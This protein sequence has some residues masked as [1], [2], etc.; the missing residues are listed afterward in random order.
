MVEWI[1]GL[2][3]WKVFLHTVLELPW[4]PSGKDCPMQEGQK[5]IRR[6]SVRANQVALQHLPC[7]SVQLIFLRHIFPVL[8]SSGA[9]LVPGAARCLPH[10]CHRTEPHS[11]HFVPC[12]PLC[13]SVSPVGGL[14]PSGSRT[15]VRR[16]RVSHK[17]WHVDCWRANTLLG[18]RQVWLGGG[19]SHHLWDP[20]RGLP[21]LLHT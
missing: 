20:S 17:A 21:L 12:I 6:A 2:S 15:P 7:L 14:Q 11:T 4:K 13:G 16:A 18:N 10:H 9:L 19:T 3:T 5:W 8:G 1:G